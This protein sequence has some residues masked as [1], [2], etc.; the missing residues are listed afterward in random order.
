MHARDRAIAANA[1]RS[2]AEIRTRLIGRHPK[3]RTSSATVG[4]AF[5][6]SEFS[7]LNRRPSVSTKRQLLLFVE[8]APDA[9]VAVELEQP[10]GITTTP[11]TAL[12]GA[13]AL[14]G[15]FAE[16]PQAPTTPQARRQRALPRGVPR[17]VMV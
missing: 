10:S 14:T 2:A 3:A 17:V 11:P 6:N 1:A 8:V 5:V 13:P 7:H 4:T 15:G 12:D 16:L 9:D